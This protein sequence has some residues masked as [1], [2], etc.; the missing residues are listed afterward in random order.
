M[1]LKLKTYII[2]QITKRLNK[3][4]RITAIRMMRTLILNTRELMPWDSCEC[5]LLGRMSCR[6]S[7]RNILCEIRAVRSPS[8]DW[9]GVR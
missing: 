5:W 6:P 2:Q 4:K 7:V 8:V 3:T 9:S 1:S